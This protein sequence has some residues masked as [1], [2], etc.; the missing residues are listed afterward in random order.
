MAIKL[1]MLSSH[2][3]PLSS[4]SPPA[5]NPSQHKLKLSDYKSLTPED[6]FPKY[7]SFGYLRIVDFVLHTL[8]MGCSGSTTGKEP[9]CRCRRQKRLGFD[10]WVR[11]IPW[12]RALQSTAPHPVDST[13]AF[14]LQVSVSMNVFDK[15]LTIL[16]FILYTKI[17][18]SCI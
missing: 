12:R 5:H 3:H 16:T 4:P 14:V 9:T 13:D 2:S 11:K 8:R 15:S 18:R 1:V 6:K 10:S 7:P 17:S